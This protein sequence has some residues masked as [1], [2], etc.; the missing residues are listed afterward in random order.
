[1][2]S[3]YTNSYDASD[4]SRNLPDYTQKLVG[5]MARDRIIAAPAKPS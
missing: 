1:V 3:A 5:A 2:W 4:L